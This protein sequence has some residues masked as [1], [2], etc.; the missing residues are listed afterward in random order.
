MDMGLL[1]THHCT[2]ICSSSQGLPSPSQKG[3]EYLKSSKD[4]VCAAAGTK[5]LLGPGDKL[6]RVHVEAAGA[7][8]LG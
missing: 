7:P 5:L 8:L 3:R 1:R 4:V 2:V 6:K